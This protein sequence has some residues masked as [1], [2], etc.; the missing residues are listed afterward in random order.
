MHRCSARAGRIYTCSSS[1][2]GSGLIDLHLH[3]V[4]TTMHADPTQHTADA[5]D[6]ATHTCT[7]TRPL[8]ATSATRADASSM[9]AASVYVEL[10]SATDEARKRSAS[11][12]RPSIALLMRHMQP[13]HVRRRNT[14]HIDEAASCVHCGYTAAA[15]NLALPY[16]QTIRKHVTSE[17]GSVSTYLITMCLSCRLRRRP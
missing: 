4:V 2:T 13:M 14:W 10:L 1:R 7:S 17:R 11:V 3:R 8:P 6:D 15:S 5:V 9:S 16:M 12:A